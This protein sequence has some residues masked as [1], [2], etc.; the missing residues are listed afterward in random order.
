M[1]TALLDTDPN[2]ERATF[3]FTIS[4]GKHTASCKRVTAGVTKCDICGK[5]RK[6]RKGHFDILIIRES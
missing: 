6:V 2:R 3:L 5:L 1:N 4:D